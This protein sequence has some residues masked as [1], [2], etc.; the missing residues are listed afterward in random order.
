MDTLEVYLSWPQEA[1]Y[2]DTHYNWA[3]K[4]INLEQPRHHVALA[5]CIKMD[6]TYMRDILT[7]SN[8]LR[9]EQNG[10]HFAEGTFICIFWNENI[11]GLIEILFKYDSKI[12]FPTCLL[13]LG[14]VR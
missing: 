7:L 6:A 10:R 9:P 4:I 12:Y 11:Y 5:D 8:S 3:H 1:C 2:L 14:V 13:W